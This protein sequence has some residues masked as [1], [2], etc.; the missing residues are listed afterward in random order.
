MDKAIE[1]VFY[2]GAK[3]RLTT[4]LHLHITNNLKWLQDSITHSY[5]SKMFFIELHLGK[6]KR[7]LGSYKGNFRHLTPFGMMLHRFACESLGIK[8]VDKDIFINDKKSLQIIKDCARQLWLSLD[9]DLSH[10]LYELSLVDDA[11]SWQKI[12]SAKIDP[13]SPCYSGNSDLF[14][15]DYQAIS[16][17]RKYEGFDFGVDREWT[18]LQKWVECENQCAENNFIWRNHHLGY[19]SK[20]DTVSV[21]AVKQVIQRILGPAPSLTRIIENSRLGPG[22]TSS[23]PSKFCSIFDKI[24]QKVI[25]VTP[26]AL[27]LFKRLKLAEPWADFWSSSELQSVQHGRLTFIPKTWDSMRPIEPPVDGNMPLQLGVAKCIRRALKRFGLDL[28][29]QASNNAELARKG[30]IDG[31]IVTRDL[32]SASDTISYEVIRQVF[33]RGWFNILDQLRTTSVEVSDPSDPSSRRVVRLSKFSAMGN[34]YTFEME[35]LL[36]LAILL[37]A[38]NRQH[39]NKMSTDIGVFG[40]DLCYPTEHDDEVKNL[41]SLFGFKSNEQKTFACGPFRESCGSDYFLGA[42]VRPFFLKTRIKDYAQLFTVVN[43]IRRTSV[44]S[45][46]YY[47]SDIRYRDVWSSLVSII[48]SKYRVFGPSS[49]GD[50]VIWGHPTD[51]ISG[52]WPIFN[53]TDRDGKICQGIWSYRDKHGPLTGVQRGINLR[54]YL[55]T[56]PTCAWALVKEGY[57]KVEFKKEVPDASLLTNRKAFLLFSLEH[58][59]ESAITPRTYRKTDK[60]VMRYRRS[61]R[62]VEIQY[63]CPPF[64]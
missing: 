44:R 47:A 22:A 4:S 37:V 50:S 38:C 55:P 42:P 39:C 54:C 36:F 8:S 58:T 61:S 17:L 53:R 13:R 25:E 64:H 43:G 41:L 35:S 23:V 33:P 3:Q 45:L 52:E 56:S 19:F 16:F 46:H 11:D 29:H 51:N 9:T 40:D 32:Q 49:Q 62:V 10:V 14:M 60:Y 5:Q 30:S 18:S 7:D 34:G 63:D 27:P 31:S 12:L 15:R 26:Q 24:D 6:D 1:F 2:A 48:P 59:T 21:I 57:Q 20:R 28:D